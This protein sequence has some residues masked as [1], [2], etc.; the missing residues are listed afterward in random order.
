MIFDSLFSALEFA[1]HQIQQ[2]TESRYVVSRYT[3]LDGSRTGM[4]QIT[5]TVETERP[6]IHPS[7]NVVAYTQVDAV[8]FS[9][10][11]IAARITEDHMVAS[12]T[13]LQDLLE[14]SK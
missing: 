9:S 14:I 7:N 3:K 12:R 2:S 6:R 4:I 1:A 10:W 11:S 8:T 5:H 13:N